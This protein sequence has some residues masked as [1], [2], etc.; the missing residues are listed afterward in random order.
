VDEQPQSSRRPVSFR[1]G[2]FLTSSGSL[3]ALVALFLETVIAVRLLSREQFGIYA[4]LMTFVNF[5]VVTVDLG[6]KT[7]AIQMIAGGDPERQSAVANNL[8]VFRLLVLVG[9]SVCIWLAQ[10]LLFLLNSALVQYV[11]YIPLMLVVA[12]FD[13]LLLGLLRGFQ[14]YH[15]MTVA[16]ILR[17]V[18]RLSLTSF[19]LIVL[20]MGLMALISSWVISFAL[21]A[22]F[23]FVVL[24]IPKRFVWQHRLLGSM[25]RF[26]FPIYITA[27]LWFVFQWVDVLLLGILAG[28]ASVAYYAVA[29]RI[30]AAMQ[31]LSDSYIVVYFPTMSAL[32]ARGKRSEAA[33]TMNLSIR[34]VSF[35]VALAAL[36]AVVFDQQIITLLFSEKYAASSRTFALLMIAFHMTFIGSLMGYALTAAGHPK[37]SLWAYLVTAVLNAVGDLLLIPF[38]GFVGPAIATLAASYGSNPLAVWLLRRSAVAVKVDA[39]VKQVLLLLLCAGLFWWAQPAQVVYK[40]GDIALFVGLSVALSVISWD[41]LALIMPKSTIKRQGSVKEASS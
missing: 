9:I 21:S 6:M 33:T 14:V 38:F 20:N 12:S 16:Q 23:Q 8:L 4:I 31:R 34:L 18:L 22:I 41:D 29:G 10:N 11:A 2:V 15:H 32:L 24:P 39:Y 13:D 1:R 5:L 27:F 3:V 7:A 26:G 30:P 40:L 28:P 36:V 19:F 37:R 35:A 25:L 17:S